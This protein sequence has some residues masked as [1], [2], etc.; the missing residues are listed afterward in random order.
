MKTIVVIPARG[1]SKRLPKKN[2]KLLGGIPLIAHSI[3]Y[4]KANSKYIDDIYVST[5]DDEIKETALKYGVKVIKRP[6]EISGDL[7][8]TVSAI[9]HLLTY[10]N[11][12]VE[13]IITLQP[14]NPFRPKNLFKEAYQI[15][16]NGR[17]ESLFTV[18]KNYKKLGYIKNTKFIPLNYTIGERSQDIETLFF[19]N[20]LLYISSRKL[21]LENTIFN[22]NAYPLLV[23]DNSIY[24]DID[25]Q[26]DFDYAEYLTTK[27]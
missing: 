9:K 18:S 21:I 20:G 15:Y 27:K 24:I 1:G 8:P 17:Y 26:E 13:T 5:N 3:Q 10:T 23:K 14:T 6:N 25:T 4:A 2:L 12:E 7:E 11:K 22:K 19:E 16:K